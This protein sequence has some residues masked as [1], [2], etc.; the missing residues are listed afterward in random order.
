MKMG[1]LRKGLVKIMRVA[2]DLGPI[3]CARATARAARSGPGARGRCGWVAGVCRIGGR[4]F[5]DK[6]GWK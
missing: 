4:W 1:G 6:W 5:S 2:L 3:N